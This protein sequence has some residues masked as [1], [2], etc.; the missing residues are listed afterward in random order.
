MAGSPHQPWLADR[1]VGAERIAAA[2]RQAKV[3]DITWLYDSSRLERD[4]HASA[5]AIRRAIEEIGA[6]INR[7]NEISTAISAAMQEQGAATREISRNV[8]EA[9]QGTVE[10]TGNIGSVTAAARETDLAANQVL[11]AAGDLGRNGEDLR[12][13]VEDFLQTVRA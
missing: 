13:Q 3:R 9:S 2:A 6:T 7:V 8:Q 10:V 1:A 11:S 5:D 4:G 12:R